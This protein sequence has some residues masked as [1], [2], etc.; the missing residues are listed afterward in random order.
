M[1]M[2]DT[3]D[4]NPENICVGIGCVN[5]P[6]RIACETTDVVFRNVAYAVLVAATIAFH[7]TDHVHIQK[8]YSGS[9]CSYLRL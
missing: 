4:I 7:V 6:I 9:R 3:C 2:S 8:G 5:N 1:L